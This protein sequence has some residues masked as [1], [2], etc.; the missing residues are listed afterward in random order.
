MVKITGKPNGVTLP[1][2]ASGLKRSKTQQPSEGR[3]SKVDEVSLKTL[4]RVKQLVAEINPDEPVDME[5]VAKIGSLTVTE[6]YRPI[7]GNGCPVNRE[8]NIIGSDPAFCR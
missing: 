5:K 4:Q 8:D 1:A 2:D 7:V 6:L 3:V